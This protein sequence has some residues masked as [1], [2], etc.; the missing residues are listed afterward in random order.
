MADQRL[1]D[2][3]PVITPAGTDIIGARQSGDTRDKRL[4][5]T[6]LLSLFAE[7]NDLTSAVVWANIPDAN[8]PESAVTQH[9]GA[10]TI[11][12]S[13]V[14]DLPVTISQAEAE[15]GTAITD[16]FFTAERV[17][18]AIAALA[19][20]GDVSKV[21]TPVDNQIGVWTG[22]GTLEGD[23]SLTYDGA[24]LQVRD[25]ASQT[26]IVAL[27]WRTS[28]N[29]RL[30]LGSSKV[31]SVAEILVNASLNLFRSTNGTNKLKIVAGPSSQTDLVLEAQTSKTRIIG[32]VGNIEMFA[33]NGA[34]DLHLAF[35]SGL[36]ITEKAAAHGDT[37]GQGQFW[38]R[39][40]DRAAMY[41]DGLGTDFVLNLL[42]DVAKVGTPVNDQVGVWTGDGTIEGTTGLTFG[43]AGLQ[44]DA[45][46]LIGNSATTGLFFAAGATPVIVNAAA[47]ATVPTLIPNKSDLNS[48]IGLAG[49][50]ILS[51]IAGG[52]Q[53]AQAK[54]VVG[55]NQF[56]I[57]PGVTQNNAAAPSLAF[58][59]GDSG[60][61]EG[62]DDQIHLATAGVS[63]GFFNSSAFTFTGTIS[64]NNSSGAAI[65]DEVASATNPT[66]IPNK[67][68]PDTG[69]GW[70][71]SNDELILVAGGIEG[72]SIAESGG[73]ITVT[74]KGPTTVEGNLLIEAA[75]GPSLLNLAATA[76]TPT[77]NPNRS[78]AN[79]G[80]GWP[81]IDQ[82]SLIAGGLDCINIAESG[83][84]RQIAF[85]VTAPIS[86]QTGVAVSSAGIHAAL[87]NLGLITA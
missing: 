13:Q 60:F 9:Q 41:T 30:D 32:S 82:L 80:I 11:T 79:S 31:G 71:A 86:L 27:D 56:I 54:E 12:K 81:G 87:V 42:G 16:R 72:V 35:G 74:L 1:P 83:A 29:P 59:D 44:V 28:F 48:G 69:I 23:A 78:D 24:A 62:A 18:Q 8:V 52:V 19:T 64:V 39:T 63:R 40:S 61:Y 73:G 3:D 17:A 43:G 15:A 7:T 50:D 14:S 68:D 10:L 6:Q 84:A 47:S 34:S 5:A 66:L 21:G 58:G 55:A 67:S 65:F 46:I 4:T 20:G 77:V 51:F 70:G 75:A 53:I 2:L 49:L 45:D 38:T 37:A 36:K 85:Y 26:N 57:A 25:P 76:T 33:A 22:D